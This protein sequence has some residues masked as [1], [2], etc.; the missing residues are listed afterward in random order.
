M[1]HSPFVV[2]SG[3]CDA[4]CALSTQWLPP[5]RL[6]AAAR[7]RSPLLGLR[8]KHQRDDGNARV[9][10]NGWPNLCRSVKKRKTLKVDCSAIRKN[11]RKVQPMLHP[12]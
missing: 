7:Q 10:D 9:P 5:A 3:A 1:D 2:G 4:P 8:P 6:P 12:G 11:L